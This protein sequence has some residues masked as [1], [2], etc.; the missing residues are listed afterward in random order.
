MAIYRRALPPDDEFST[1]PILKAT[2]KIV[3]LILRWDKILCHTHCISSPTVTVSRMSYIMSLSCLKL[4]N[5]YF[6]SFGWGHLIIT[7]PC[8]RRDCFISYLG[9][10]QNGSYTACV[11]SWKRVQASRF[12]PQCFLEEFPTR[13]LSSP[14]QPAS[15]ASHAS[16]ANQARQPNKPGS[17]PSQPANQLAK[18]ASQVSLPSQPTKPVSQ[19]KAS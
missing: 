5:V 4:A 14:N 17:Q 2:L 6:V 16:P 12:P 7:H 10:A 1:F 15:K 13:N 18:T 11:S 9:S 3:I 19:A 8:S